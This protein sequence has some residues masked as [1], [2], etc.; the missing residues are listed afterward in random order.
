MHRVEFKDAEALGDPD[1]LF[2]VGDRY[3]A[4]A[5]RQVA[6]DF[7]RL[8]HYGSEVRSCRFCH[9]RGG[10]SIDIQTPRCKK[11]GNPAGH[12]VVP[13]AGAIQHYGIFAQG[14]IQGLA[15]VQASLAE[16]Q[17]QHGGIQRVGAI[18]IQFFYP[19]HQLGITHHYQTAVGHHWKFSRGGNDLFGGNVES[20]ANLL[21]KVLAKFVNAVVDDGLTHQIRIIRLIAHQQIQ[22]AENAFSGIFNDCSALCCD[23]SSGLGHRNLGASVLPTSY[24][25]YKYK[26]YLY[27]FEARESISS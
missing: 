27:H 17:H 6:A 21:V 15:P 19:R 20:V 5:L 3:R 13:E 18:H 10:I 22:R 7:V 9:K 16:Q 26:N 12:L 8:G 14:L 11:R 4:G 25:S 23:V 1:I 24:A 2:H